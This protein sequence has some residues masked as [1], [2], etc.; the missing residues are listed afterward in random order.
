MLTVET[1]FNKS[2]E[3]RLMATVAYF[4]TYTSIEICILQFT[5]IGVRTVQRDYFAYK[6]G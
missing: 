1:Q 2:W 4:E 5:W 6:S 3:S